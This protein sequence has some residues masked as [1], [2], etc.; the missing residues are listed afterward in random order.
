MRERDI[1][2]GISDMTIASTGLSTKGRN[3]ACWSRQ[4]ASPR[5]ATISVQRVRW[6]RLVSR[7]PAQLAH[8]IWRREMRFVSHRIMSV[9]GGEHRNATGCGTW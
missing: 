8:G 5:R 3:L 7:W 9:A 1:S 6:Y 2:S 4:Y